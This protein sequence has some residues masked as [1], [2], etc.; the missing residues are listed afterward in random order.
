MNIKEQVVFI[1][2]KGFFSSDNI[3][4]M[5]KE[6]LSYIIPLR[7]QKQDLRNARL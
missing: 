5:R 1:A 2:D 3:A 7:V 4:M 6:T